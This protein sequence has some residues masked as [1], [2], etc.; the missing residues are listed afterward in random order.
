[1]RSGARTE[2]SG[3]CRYQS[4]SIHQRHQPRLWTGELSIHNGLVTEDVDEMVL[5]FHSV[6]FVGISH[7]QNE[8]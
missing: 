6:Q 2:H 5:R 4:P 8:V 3:G 1:M 7:D